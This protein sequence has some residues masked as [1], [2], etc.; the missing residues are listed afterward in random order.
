MNNNDSQFSFHNATQIQQPKVSKKPGPSS[1]NNESVLVQRRSSHT[2]FSTARK[3]ELFIN[4]S[5]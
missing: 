2:I 3:P 1:Y 4:K 5:F